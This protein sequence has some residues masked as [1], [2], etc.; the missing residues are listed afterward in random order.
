MV[1][2]LCRS[3]KRWLMRVYYHQQVFGILYDV[4]IAILLFYWLGIENVAK[5][6]CWLREQLLFKCSQTCFL[7][8]QFATSSVPPKNILEVPLLAHALGLTY[9]KVWRRLTVAQR[10]WDCARGV[11]S[12]LQN[13]ECRGERGGE[14]SQHVQ[15]TLR[16]RN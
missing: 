13:G 12:P 5:T 7:F 9:S 16:R 14:Y 3:N 1:F 11:G 8:H 4:K 2:V 6:V 15:G 10:P